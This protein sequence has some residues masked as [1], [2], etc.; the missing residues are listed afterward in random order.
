MTKKWPQGQKSYDTPHLKVLMIA[1]SGIQHSSD[2]RLAKTCET[3]LFRLPGCT[4]RTTTRTWT[5]SRSCRP[6]PTCC[7]CRNSACRRSWA[8]PRS[9]SPPWWTTGSRA[10]CTTMKVRAGSRVELFLYCYECSSWVTF[11]SPKVYW[12]LSHSMTCIWHFENYITSVTININTFVY[13]PVQCHMF[14]FFW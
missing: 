14:S 13:T 6:W 10:C 8:S 11:T 7:Q 12:T 3:R 2:N 9:R 1:P 4:T 5:G